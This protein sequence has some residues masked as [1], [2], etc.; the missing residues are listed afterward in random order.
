[1][2]NQ[3]ES[4]H[5]RRSILLVAATVAL[6]IWSATALGAS[7]ARGL[8]PRQQARLVAAAP[9][10][11][12]A[13]GSS[14][15]IGGDTAVAGSPDYGGSGLDG[16]GAA[17]VFTRTG[18]TWTQQ[19]Q[20]LAGD[21]ATW[22]AFGA[23]VAVSGDTAL[24]G[25]PGRSAGAREEAGAV[26]IF[27]RINGAWIQ[28]AQLVAPDAAAQAG[29]G[30]SV[31]LS[32]ETAVVGAPY[33][34]A[35]DAAEA[36]AV[37][38]FTRSG[39]TW[40]LQAELTA[41]DAAAGDWLGTSVAV[42]GDT[43]VAGASG[44]G[45]GAAYVFTRSGAV[46][47][48]QGVLQGVGAVAGDA[49]GDSVALEGDVAVA[50]APAHDVS[51]AEG[52][53]VAYVFTRAGA[54]WTQAAELDEP[55]PAGGDSFGSSVS[56]SGST[57]LV[58]AEY[59]DT[60]SLEDAGAAYTFVRSGVTWT[61]EGELTA[62]DA[63]AGDQFGGCAGL[64]GRTALTGADGHAAG[65]LE[66]AGAAYAFTLDGQPIPPAITSFSP[67]AAGVG[68]R[69]TLIGEGFTGTT[70]VRF[71]GSAK[72]RFSVLS[73]ARISATV[74]AGAKT[75]RITVTAPLGTATSAR[76][77]TVL[78][79]SVIKR[80]A[81]LS[82]KRGAVVTI[83]GR[84]FGARRGKGTVTFGK[85]KCLKFVSWN[86]RK[87]RCKVPRKVRPGRVAVRVKTLAG[88]SNAKRLRVKR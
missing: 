5:V 53:G 88:K 60:F 37:Y 42:D 29:F 13:F 33:R 47:S 67:R 65:D 45:P 64:S 79:L 8:I 82:C 50:G 71:G 30:A 43:V 73:D 70:S 44:R 20:L 9:A 22:D 69:V 14:V 36:G 46:W 80:I 32:D 55:N 83:A 12:A 54:S 78:H 48:Q 75:G 57:A 17:Y 40:T 28:Q 87:I 1:V 6:G 72:A 52:A 58:G 3:F 68:K 38:V 66:E 85:Q 77:F 41:A 18:E 21:A 62:T 81:P 39:S 86:D 49:F 19:A 31:A 35:A 51:A 7:T 26:Y 63:A 76:S 25:A 34:D 15:A 11:E 74:P 2:S 61:Q 16:A 84:W 10:R 23:A 4:V 56:L 59:R 27:T 24:V